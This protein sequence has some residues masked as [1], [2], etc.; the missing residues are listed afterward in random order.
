MIK[1]IIKFFQRLRRRWFLSK[2]AKAMQPV[3]EKM[4]VE[5]KQLRREINIFLRKYFGIDAKSKYIPAN[6]RN[7]EEVRLAVLDKFSPKMEKLNVTYQDL[8]K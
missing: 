2:Q 4:I 7:K 6:Y 3:V 5:R 8:F 1:N